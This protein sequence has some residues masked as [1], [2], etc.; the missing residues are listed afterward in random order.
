MFPRCLPDQ[1]LAQQIA[2]H[3]ARIA[4][5]ESPIQRTNLPDLP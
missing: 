3:A 2:R 1:H 5:E 4:T